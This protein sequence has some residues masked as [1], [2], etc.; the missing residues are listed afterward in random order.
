MH[1]VQEAVSVATITRITSLISI[2]GCLVVAKQCYVLKKQ[3]KLTHMDKLILVLCLIDLGLAIVWFIGDWVR[4]DEFLCDFQVSMPLLHPG[5]A[6]AGEVKGVDVSR[7][8]PLLQG[9][10]NQVFGLADILWTNA[11]AFHIYSLIVLN[12]TFKKAEKMFKYYLILTIGLSLFLGICLWLRGLYSFVSLWCWITNYDLKFWCFYSFVIGTAVF[13]GYVHLRVT[14]VIKKDFR[15]LT[16]KAYKKDL[17]TINNK[18]TQV[19][20][21]FLITHFFG[22]LN[23][24]VESGIKDTFLFTAVMQ[25]GS[26]P[27][28]SQHSLALGQKPELLSVTD[29]VLFL[30]L[31]SGSPDAP[32]WVPQL[33]GLR[34]SRP[35][36]PAHLPP[37]GAPLPHR[38]QDLLLRVRTT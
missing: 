30:A 33:A 20:I 14:R 7:P 8:R 19:L 25:V 34:S 9:F 6:S 1:S 37:D 10:W 18:V 2:V 11:I 31:W 27:P 35:Q 15:S 38:R 21:I 4:K 28:H 23:R 3:K 17:V 13:I 16:N 22:L 29:M 24:S 5:S 36:A 12:F 26:L 32:A